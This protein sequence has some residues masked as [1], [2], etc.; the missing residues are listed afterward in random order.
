MRN[1]RIIGCRLSHAE[2][3]LVEAYAA[4]TG[5]FVSHV[6][7]RAVLREVREVRAAVAATPQ[8]RDR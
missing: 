8:P 6:I 4:A 3:D 5:E 1:S 7:R 2:A